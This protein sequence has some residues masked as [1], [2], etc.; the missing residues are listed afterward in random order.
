[1]VLP[2]LEPTCIIVIRI[3]GLEVHVWLKNLEEYPRGVHIV[4]GL[5]RCREFF[6]DNANFRRCERRGFKAVG[7]PPEKFENLSRFPAF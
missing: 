3:V 2:Y 5:G 7:P 6:P 4:M 1:M